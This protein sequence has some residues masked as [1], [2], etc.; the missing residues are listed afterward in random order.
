MLPPKR[1]ETG[2]LISPLLFILATDILQMTF[3]RARHDLLT[4]HWY[5]SLPICRLYIIIVLLFFWGSIE[6]L[7]KPLQIR[8]PSNLHPGRLIASGGRNPSMC[9]SYPTHLLPWSTSVYQKIPSDSVYLTSHR[10]PATT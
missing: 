3:S 9:A 6:I 10:R 8:V 1:A 5:H 2:D 4:F 7:S